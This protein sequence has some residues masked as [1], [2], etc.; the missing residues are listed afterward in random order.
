MIENS[1]TGSRVYTR[2]H[3]ERL[4]GALRQLAAGR[5]HLHDIRFGATGT[6]KRRAVGGFDVQKLADELLR[7]GLAGKSGHNS[8]FITA[9]GREFV[10]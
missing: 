7:R 9:T 10:A 8:Y 3:E 4:K 6:T 2:A 1:K 5:E